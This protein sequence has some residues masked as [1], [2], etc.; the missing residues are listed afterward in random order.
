MAYDLRN[1]EVC[2]WTNFL[3]PSFSLP[4]INVMS[5]QQ[6]DSIYF[7][8]VKD[9]LP[10]TELRV[11]ARLPGSSTLPDEWDASGLMRSSSHTIY[12]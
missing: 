4:E 7:V 2:S 6:R 12:V 5:Y 11:F 8:T 10:D 9:I 1:D 3:Q